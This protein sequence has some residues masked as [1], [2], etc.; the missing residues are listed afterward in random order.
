MKQTADAVV[1]AGTG[2]N[3]KVLL[4]RRKNPPFQNERAFPGGFIDEGES[5][6]DACLREL[7]EE[8]GL[9]L[10]ADSAVVLSVRRKKGRDPRGHTITHPF[11]FWLDAPVNVTAGD[12]ADSA[13]W[14]NLLDVGKM[15]FDHGAILCEALGKCWSFM[16][17]YSDKLAGKTLPGEIFK[18]SFK[19]NNELVFFGGSFNP[20]HEGHMVCVNLFCEKHR[21]ATL[22]VVPDSNP[23]KH[24]MLVR[25]T[26]QCYFA[27]FIEIC[28]TLG[29]TSAAVYPGFWGSEDTNPT[30]NWFK[31]V[32][33]ER[34]GLLMG[35]DG[36][37]SIFGWKDAKLLIRT[38]DVLYVV[39]RVLERDERDEVVLKIKQCNNNLEMEIFPEHDF[40]H[41]SSTKLRNS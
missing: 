35:D 15:A 39:P 38:L 7:D 11:L 32:N 12:D 21:E 8:A 41:I 31:Y 40:K 6:M 14:V 18:N 4:I 3:L 27:S 5:E 9:Q 28:R 1:L 23:W 16:P 17:G 37:G 29:D 2:E 30:I 22:V 20:W 33:A 10:S 19:K 13:D 34:K 26:K 36:A 25:P 24:S